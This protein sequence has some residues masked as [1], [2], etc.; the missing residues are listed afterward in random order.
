MPKRGLD[1]ETLIT[2]GAGDTEEE[3]RGANGGNE[4]K[5]KAAN[6]EEAR[7]RGERERGKR[8]R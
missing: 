6:G 1:K 8:K 5:V 7:N 4:E 3:T 2:R